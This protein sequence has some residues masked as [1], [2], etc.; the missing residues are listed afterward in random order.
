MNLI[1][2]LN[3]TSIKPLITPTVLLHDWPVPEQQQRAIQGCSL[4]R[5]H[6]EIA[7]CV[8]FA[9]PYTT[10]ESHLSDRQDLQPGRPL[11]YGKS[12]TDACLGFAETAHLID[13]LAQ[14]KGDAS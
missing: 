4:H 3:I 13:H 9:K 6:L 5:D 2:D 1:R 12:I 10:I 11:E 14:A 8:Y 7:M